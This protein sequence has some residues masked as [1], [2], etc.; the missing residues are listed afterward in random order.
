MTDRAVAVAEA[1]HRALERDAAE[2]RREWEALQLSFEKRGVTF[3]G[4]P[5]ATLLRPQFVARPVWDDLVAG[6]RSLVTLCDRVSRHVFGGST[7]AL[8]DFLAVPESHRDVLRLDTASPDVALSRVDAF[9]EPLTGRA[10]F[11]EL[12]SDAPAGFGYA[13][14][15]ARAFE[16]LPV[17]QALRP[18]H[19]HAHEDS[20]PALAHALLDASPVDRPTVA[21]VDLRDVR[22]RP[23]QAILAEELARYGVDAVLSDPRDLEIAGGRLVSNGRAIDV[24]YR[25]TVIAELLAIRADARAFLD[26]Y[27]RGLAVFVNSFRCYFSED[28]AFF[29]ILTDERYE[30][31]LLPDERAFVARHVPWTRRVEDRMTTRAGKPV[32]LLPHVELERANLVLKPAHAYGG[33]SVYIGS[34]TRPEDWS[35]TLDR[36]SRDGGWIVQERVTIP[37]EEFPVFD[38][39]GRLSFR[40]LKVNTN[41]FYVAGH[42]AGAVSRVS[43]DSVI[44]VSAGGGS[45][46][47]FVV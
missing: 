25:R 46:P 35:V 5:M 10:R 19:P 36:A 29:A 11:I 2:A 6:A 14:R 22:T 43:R 47:C 21:I 8:M 45:V 9:V 30:D 33:K 28:K 7:E 20:V 38:A 26:A 12:N 42:E 18:S 44:N 27:E 1:Y 32:D 17:L 34:E 3:D 16:D 37:E 24:V 41:P 31:L 40:P 23:D 4:K 13:D 15:M 39:D